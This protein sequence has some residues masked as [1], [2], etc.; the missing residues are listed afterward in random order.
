MVLK[1]DKLTWLLLAILLLPLM[2]F[3]QDQVHIVKKGDTLYALGIKYGVSVAQIQQLNNMR[4]T[5]LSVGQRLVIKKGAPPPAASESRESAPAPTVTPSAD[6][7]YTV[8]RGDNLFQ[9]ARAHGL[10]LQELL[11]LNSY[12]NSS[13]KIFPGTRIRVKEAS[14]RTEAELSPA[15]DAELPVISTAAE[16]DTVV[17]E[18]VY[19]VQPKDTLYKIAREYDVSVDELKRINSLSS[20]DIKVGQRIYI[21][22]SPRAA[23]APAIRPPITEEE[24]LKMDKIR[25]DLI[26]PVEAKIL[27]EYGLRNGRPHKGIDLGAKTGTPIYAVLDGTVVYSGVQGAYG[28]VVVIEHPDFIMTVYAHNEKN[29]VIVG[30]KVT[31]G[32]QI[33]TVGATG[34]ATGSHLHFEYR[35]KGKAI[36]P[37]KVLPLN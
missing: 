36:N 28:N 30:D 5:N 11:D 23:N 9:I 6:E 1:L 18:K 7:L 34:N 4:G 32:Q 14:A 8:K 26:M 15:T 19:I 3:A 22:G 12:D 25:G 27:S 13:V 31:K 37:R 20:N 17:I 16:A 29:L 33:A 35:I 21:S 24:L 2:A 10:S